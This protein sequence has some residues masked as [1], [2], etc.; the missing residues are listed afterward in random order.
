MVERQDPDNFT[1]FL[2]RERCALEIAAYVFK[3]Q[4]YFP[5]DFK[6]LPALLFT[7]ETHLSDS[8]QENPSLYNWKIVDGT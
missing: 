7:T 2:T 3:F 8:T 5:F 6:S 1:R 4:E